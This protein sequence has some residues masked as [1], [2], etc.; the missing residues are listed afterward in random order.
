MPIKW[1]PDPEPANDERLLSPIQAAAILGVRMSTVAVWADRGR[2]PCDSQTPG[3]HR[4]YRAADV[5]RLRVE[6]GRPEVPPP[7]R[8]PHLPTRNGRQRELLS[9]GQVAAVVDVDIRTV[10]R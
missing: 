10:R 6:L 3:G 7:P 8:T 4:R 1:H 5:E 9:A 2:I